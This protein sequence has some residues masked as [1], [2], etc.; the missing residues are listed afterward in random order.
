MSKKATDK[1]LEALHGFL[2]IVLKNQLEEQYEDEDT[3]KKSYIASPALVAQV[4]QFL[5]DNEITCD[6]TQDDNMSALKDLL[7]R[8]RRYSDAKEAAKGLDNEH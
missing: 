7:S 3:G 8:K 1:E 4:R 5:K 2:A 6:I